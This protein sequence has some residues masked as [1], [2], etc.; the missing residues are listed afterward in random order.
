MTNGNKMINIFAFLISIILSSFTHAAD[1]R[2][3]KLRPPASQVQI[4]VTPLPKEIGACTQFLKE[5][6][7]CR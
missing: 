7:L 2:I 5:L 6:K 3:P 4:G 1:L